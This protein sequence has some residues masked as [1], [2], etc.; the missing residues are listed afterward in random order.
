MAAPP[1]PSRGPTTG[2]NCYI[3]PTFSGISNKKGTK[4][5]M[6]ALTLPSRGPKR[7]PNCYVTLAFSGISSKGEQN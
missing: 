7:R 4:S 5:E 2:R 1:L 3:T 6:V